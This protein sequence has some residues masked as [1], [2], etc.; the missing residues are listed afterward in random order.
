M[1][2]PDKQLLIYDSE[3]LKSYNYP[4]AKMQGLISQNLLLKCGKHIHAPHRMNP[5]NDLSPSATFR[6]KCTNHILRLFAFPQHAPS[7]QGT[8]SRGP[9]VVFFPSGKQVQFQSHIIMQRTISSCYSTRGLSQPLKS[10]ILMNRTAEQTRTSITHVYNQSFLKDY[11]GISVY[12]IF[13]L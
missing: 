2:N 9:A 10:E 5:A 1:R 12:Y 4:S 13:S 11:Y 3:N 6:P 7:Q 8:S